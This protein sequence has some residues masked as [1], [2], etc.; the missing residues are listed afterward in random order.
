MQPEAVEKDPPAPPVFAEVVRL[1]PVCI[2][3]VTSSV[4][5]TPPV[6]CGSGRPRE[7]RRRREPEV[8]SPVD[9]KRD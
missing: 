6:A 8:F 3:S 2:R 5:V 9:R 1:Y 4:G 7:D